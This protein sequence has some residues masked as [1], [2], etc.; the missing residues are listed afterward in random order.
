MSI[1]AQPLNEPTASKANKPPDQRA[2]S[3]G[4]LSAVPGLAHHEFPGQASDCCIPCLKHLWPSSSFKVY[5]NAYRHRGCEASMSW[6]LAAFNVDG[7]FHSSNLALNRSLAHIR[8]AQAAIKIVA[9]TDATGARIGLAIC[10][11]PRALAKWLRPANS[12]LAAV[13][14]ARWVLCRRGPS[15]RCLGYHV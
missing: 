1:V 14:S 15:P 2:Q 4:Q 7:Y 6:F 10:T 5:K 9:L 3:I 13:T 12:A 8:P 11:M